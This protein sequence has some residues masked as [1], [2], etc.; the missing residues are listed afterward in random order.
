MTPFAGQQRYGCTDITSGQRLDK[1]SLSRYISLQL[2]R[3]RHSPPEVLTGHSLT[4]LVTYGMVWC[5]MVSPTSL[6]LHALP[7]DAPHADEVWLARASSAPPAPR[8][9]APRLSS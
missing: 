8:C 4:C 6:S 7:H 9:L 5:G 3:D 1:R 2:W